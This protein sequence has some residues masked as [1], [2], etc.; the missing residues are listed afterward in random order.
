MD[1]QAEVII[2]ED[3]ERNGEGQELR[4]TQASHSRDDSN[5]PA[6]PDHPSNEDR[7]RASQSGGRGG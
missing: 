6:R 5:Q 1:D 4:G 7:G 2:I 3:D